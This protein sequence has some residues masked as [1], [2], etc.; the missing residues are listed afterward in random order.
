MFVIFLF[1]ASPAPLSDAQSTPVA[2]LINLPHE[3]T[4]KL[5]HIILYALLGAAWYY[6]FR[7]LNKFTPAFTA[8]VPLLLAVFYSVLDEFHQTFV[9]GRTGLLQDV[10]LDSLAAGLGMA[11][12]ALLYYLTRT[13][14]QRVARKKQ[15]AKI[16]ARN[17]RVF[18]AGRRDESR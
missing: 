15:I 16:W 9:P 13:K 11:V 18:K 1:S 17:S 4:R 12:F 6:Y 14:S 5:A 3:I 8:F 2:E 7:A 10:F